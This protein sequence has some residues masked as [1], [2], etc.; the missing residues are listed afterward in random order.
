[1]T[2]TGTGKKTILHP[3]ACHSH[4]SGEDSGDCLLRLADGSYRIGYRAG[5]GV[6]YEKEGAAV[7]PVDFLPLY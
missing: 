7:D 2:D 1:M 6:W 4:V 3:I 5:D